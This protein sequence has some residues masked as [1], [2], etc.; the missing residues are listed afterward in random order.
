MTGSSRRGVTLADVRELAL[1]LPRTE[2]ALVRDSA[3]FRVRGIVYASVSPD[4]TLL[5]L[6][7][8]RDER[9]DLVAAEPDKFVMPA[10]S[11]ERF[12]WV[13]ARMD[14]LDVDEM[15]ELVLDAWRMVV[16]QK[17]VR[18]H[19]AASGADQSSDEQP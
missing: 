5:G 4:E 18:Q 11:D 6:A 17:V 16:P 8:P 1:T 14:V 9:A 7:Y 15:R 2:E 3:R 13:R 19:L 10:R 12:H